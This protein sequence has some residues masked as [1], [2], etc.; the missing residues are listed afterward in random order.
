MIFWTRDGHRGWVMVSRKPVRFIGE[1][2]PKDGIPASLEGRLGYLGKKHRHR[3]TKFF[4]TWEVFFL[5]WNRPKMLYS[6][7]FERL[8]K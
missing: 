3:S 8:Y 1:A 4:D 6:D 2:N 5:G 7:E